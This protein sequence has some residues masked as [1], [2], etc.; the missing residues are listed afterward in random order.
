[1]S[2]RTPAADTA[3]R[4]ADAQR[5]AIARSLRAAR[6]RRTRPAAESRENA[7]MGRRSYG[8]GSLFVRR[9]TWYG[10]WWVGNQRVKRALGPV[11]KPGTREGLTQTQAEREM[12]R[13]MESEAA[14]VRSHDR[15]TL[16]EAGERYVDHLEHVVERKRT[17]IE[18]YRGYLRRHFDPYFGDRAIERIEP[19]HVMGYLKRKR[20]QGCRRRRCRTT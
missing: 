4:P 15:L 6:E 10:R 2:W 20:A 9:E 5:V 13:R 1:V 17:T 11:R 18:D 7:P 8:T 19:G 16:I 3:T 14:V 12:R